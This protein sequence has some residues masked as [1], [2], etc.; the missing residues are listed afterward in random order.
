MFFQTVLTLLSAVYILGA[1]AAVVVAIL[2]PNLARATRRDHNLR[3]EGAIM[4]EAEYTL[5]HVSD[6]T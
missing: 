5:D 2:G 3:A 6:P 1:V 4:R